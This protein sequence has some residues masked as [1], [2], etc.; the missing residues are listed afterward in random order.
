MNDGGFTD[1]WNNDDASIQSDDDDES[2]MDDEPID[3]L[4]RLTDIAA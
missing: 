3:P 4:A 2:T 1:E